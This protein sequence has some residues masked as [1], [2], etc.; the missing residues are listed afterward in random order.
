MLMLTKNQ[1]TIDSEV[2]KTLDSV[3]V[4]PPLCD[5]VP[6]EKL[7]ENHSKDKKKRKNSMHR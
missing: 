6:L 2:V 7:Q 3:T 1:E 5:A 4:I